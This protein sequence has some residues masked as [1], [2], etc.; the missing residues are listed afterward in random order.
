MLAVLPFMGTKS[1]HE[2]NAVKTILAGCINAVTVVVFAVKGVVQWE[3]ALPMAAAAI[4]G[5]YAGGHFAR[6]LPPIYVRAIVIVIGLTLGGYY[7][8]RQFGAGQ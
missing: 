1:I 6:R 4:L 5:G 7:L 2:T 8:W 3:Y